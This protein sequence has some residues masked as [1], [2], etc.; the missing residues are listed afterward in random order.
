M[1]ISLF[2][3]SA[4][5][6]SACQ[7][8]LDGNSTDLEQS[9]SSIAV[10]MDD[11]R[12]FKP[13]LNH[14]YFEGWADE[15]LPVWVY[16]PDGVDVSDA[17]I[18]IMMHGAKRGAARYLSEWD[19]YAERDGFIIIAPEFTRDAFPGSAGYNLGN[20]VP[21][22]A[23][24][25]I[26]QASWTFS[27]IEPLFDHV[28]DALDSAQTGYTLYGHSAGSQF[29][30]RYMY[31]NPNARAKRYLAANAGWYT[32]PDLEI[33][34]PVGLGGLGWTDEDL[35]RM[36]EQ[37]LFILIG[38]QDNDPNHESLKRDDGVHLQGA[39]RFARGQHFYQKG[40]SEAE[41]I[42]ADFGWRLRVAEGVAHSNGGMAAAAVDLVK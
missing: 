25:V 15:R 41:R 9:V 10:D 31:F 30:H 22:G 3:L 36:L 4:L 16:I 1:R 2:C 28:L 19:Q 5:A 7:P 35:K 27:A 40:K 20:R 26:D 42:G 18:L 24:T 21:R 37:D 14:F 34:Y 8:A 29:T 38:D 33:E 6:L 17:P 32:F 23:D 13:G 12:A 11:V 39:H